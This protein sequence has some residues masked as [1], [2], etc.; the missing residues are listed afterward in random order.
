[1]SSSRPK[2]RFRPNVPPDKRKRTALA[3]I[4]CRRRKRKCLQQESGVCAQCQ[5]HRI[6]CHFEPIS[7]S[8]D[9]ILVP[10][11]TDRRSTKYTSLTPKTLRR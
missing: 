3:C 1:M 11:G 10:G 7:N 8:A 2:K 9:R 5:E 6:D 4:A